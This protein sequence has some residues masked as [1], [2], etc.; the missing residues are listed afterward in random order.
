[1]GRQEINIGAQTIPSR[2]FT[3]WAWLCFLGVP[4]IGVGALID[5]VLF[6]TLLR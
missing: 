5:Y 4:V 2:Q 6:L 1:M 3:G